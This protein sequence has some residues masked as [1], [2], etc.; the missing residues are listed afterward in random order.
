MST[1]DLGMASGALDL[2]MPWRDAVVVQAPRLLMGTPQTAT[3]ALRNTGAAVT[4]TLQ[5]F[6][7]PPGAA[8]RLIAQETLSLAPFETRRVGGVFT[9]TVT[10][11]HRFRGVVTAHAPLDSDASNNQRQWDV[12]AVSPGKLA[13][14]AAA[15]NFIA[16]AGMPVDRSITLTNVGGLGLIVQRAALADG[17][18]SSTGFRLWND[19]CSGQALAPAE[20]CRIT[21]RYTP[22]AGVEEEVVLEITSTDPDRPAQEILLMG[23]VGTLQ[24]VVYL[25]LVVR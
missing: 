5:L 25:P 18:A 17:A 1:V 6:V 12:I 8:E 14:D 4:A 20:A 7:R 22:S 15:V 16:P 13:P 11:V 10:G 9:A 23:K 24:S 3:V 2:T 21:V 19:G